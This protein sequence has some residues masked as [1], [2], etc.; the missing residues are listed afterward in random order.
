MSCVDEDHIPNQFSAYCRFLC[1]EG[2]IV[3][4]FCQVTQVIGLLSQ[5]FSVFD[6]CEGLVVI[7]TTGGRLRSNLAQAVF[8]SLFISFILTALEFPIVFTCCGKLK[9][10]CCWTVVQIDLK[11][12]LARCRMVLA[13]LLPMLT[14]APTGFLHQVVP[15]LSKFLSAKPLHSLACHPFPGQK[16]AG[17][18]SLLTSCIYWDSSVAE[19]PL[20]EPT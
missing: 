16:W 2:E 5:W 1:R 18:M 20:L 8:L 12:Q 15:L 17:A 9:K 19:V 10:K 3:V 11:T 6:T 13:D 7:I 4:L 14:S